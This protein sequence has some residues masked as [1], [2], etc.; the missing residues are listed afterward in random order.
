M[1]Q[2]H[3]AITPEVCYAEAQHSLYSVIDLAPNIRTP[4][5]WADTMLCHPEKA[6]T[7]RSLTVRFDLS[8]IIVPD[9]LLSSL[10]AISQALGSLSRLER[11]VLMGHPLAMMHPIHT[12]ILDGVTGNLSVFHNSLFPSGAI[13]PF[14]SRQTL[15]R[16]WK[17]AGVCPG[18]IITDAML[19]RLTVL[20]GHVSILASFKTPRPLE[21]ARLEINDW[22]RGIAKDLESISFFGATLTTIVVEDSS[23]DSN[24]LRLAELFTHLAKITPNLKTLTYTQTLESAFGLQVN[25]QPGLLTSL[26]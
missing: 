21:T 12:W 24:R 18:G 8:F 1:K 10:K 11:L 6:A 5:L 16:E 22:H 3:A 15:L 20:D 26:Y 2:Y 4:V 9:L 14:L 7:V 13:V 23:T 25:F 17:Q 19:P